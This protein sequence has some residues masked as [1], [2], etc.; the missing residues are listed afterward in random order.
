MSED[1]E[2]QIEALTRI[3]QT[4]TAEQ[5]QQENGVD[6]E[7]PYL[8]PF[9]KYQNIDKLTREILGELI[10]H[11][12]IC[13]GSN[14]SVKSN[15]LT[16]SALRMT[17]SFAM[18]TSL[19]LYFKDNSNRMLAAKFQESFYAP[20]HRLSNRPKTKGGPAVSVKRIA[21]GDV[22]DLIFQDS[23]LPSDR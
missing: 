1:Y 20:A 13:E 16:S 23:W 2:Q 10:D 22:D 15:A 19:F 11:I 4:L 17:L 6:V 3:M 7:S 18:K 8:S 21:A 5:E 9:L 14:I 12:K